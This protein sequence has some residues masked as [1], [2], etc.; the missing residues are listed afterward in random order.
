[1][2]AAN[3]VAGS[4]IFSSTTVGE[5]SHKYDTLFAPAG[6]AFIIWSFLFLLTIAFV[7]YEWVLLK[8]GDPKGYINRTAYWFALSNVAN[9]VWLYCW[10]NELL[11]WS[12]LIILLLLFTLCMLTVRL[13]AEL[14][15]E[16]VSTIVFVW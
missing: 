12:V 13:D 15:D 5:V 14:S 4:G 2:L 10:I 16:P 8:N 3:F 1:M 7:G 9:T 6:Y 11:G